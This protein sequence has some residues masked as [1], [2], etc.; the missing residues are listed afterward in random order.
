[1]EWAPHIDGIDNSAT[2]MPT[3]S[4]LPRAGIT[5]LDPLDEITGRADRL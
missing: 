2:R 3:A 1:V 4:N 5:Q